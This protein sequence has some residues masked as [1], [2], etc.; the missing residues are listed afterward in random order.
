MILQ[1]LHSLSDH[2]SPP[3]THAP[4]LSCVWYFPLSPHSLHLLSLSL[5]A[6]LTHA[7]PP[8]QSILPVLSDV[9]WTRL[10]ANSKYLRPPPSTHSSILLSLPCV[11]FQPLLPTLL[12]ISLITSPMPSLPEPTSFCFMTFLPGREPHSFLPLPH[13]HC[14]F[15]IFHFSLL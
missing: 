12:P 5:P 8:E 1:H 9:Y 4:S 13:L 2:T 3:S 10:I 7:R 14:P 15:P 11:H 6:T